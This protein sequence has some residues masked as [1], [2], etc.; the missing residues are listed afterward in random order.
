VFRG[1]IFDFNGVIAD[2]HPV[3]LRVWKKVLDSVL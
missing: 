3:H 2:S 1:A